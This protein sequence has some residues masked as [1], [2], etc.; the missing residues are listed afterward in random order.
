MA[1]M[2][3][4][5]KLLEKRLSGHME[6]LFIERLVV[7]VFFT[8]VKLSDGA[9]GVSYTPVKSIPEAVCCPSSA[10]RAL[11]PLR[12]KGTPAAEVMGWLETW[13]PLKRASAIA[14]VNALQ[15][16]CNAKGAAGEYRLHEGADGLD[17]VPIEGGGEV[18]MVGA[19]VPLMR[20]LRSRGA[21]WW[22]IEQDPR[23]LKGDELNHY[24]PWE[25]AEDTLGR[26]QV[27][28]V[29]G[30]TLVTDTLDWILEKVNPSAHISVIGPTASLPPEPLFARGVKLVGGIRVNDPDGLLDVLSAAGSGYHFY[31]RFAEK[32]VWE[33]P[34][35]SSSG[36]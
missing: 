30:A 22:V 34:Q 15:A 25:H 19:M 12:I 26:A 35:G 32:V 9:C 17:L 29:T 1:I 28:V 24:V 5:V 8:G 14:L 16:S 20:T 27:V 23:T 31:G 18:V 3:E 36:A 11:D 6:G 4:A 10:G 7:G 2:H 13:E 33:A 21:H